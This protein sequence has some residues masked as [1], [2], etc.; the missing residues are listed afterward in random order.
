M[1]LNFTRIRLNRLVIVLFST[2]LFKSCNIQKQANSG[3]ALKE[4][5][6][7]PGDSIQI[8]R[9]FLSFFD[10][11]HIDT[12]NQNFEEI[13]YESE[14]VNILIECK[15]LSETGEWYEASLYLT[16]FFLKKKRSK[17]LLDK[18]YTSIE[19]YKE[20]GCLSDGSDPFYNIVIKN[21]TDLY[22]FKML[23]L[24]KKF[25]GNKWEYCYSPYEN[26]KNILSPQSEDFLKNIEIYNLENTIFTF[27]MYDPKT[28]ELTELT[29]DTYE[30]KKNVITIVLE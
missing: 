7:L 21:Q 30:I 2:F 8:D 24:S 26:I 12:I 5:S 11:N 9:I 16:N 15:E 17:I 29:V 6:F 4:I 25:K 13:K 19:Y 10:K 23:E 28:H 1:E 18:D 20:E 27:G 14:R 3:S 22:V